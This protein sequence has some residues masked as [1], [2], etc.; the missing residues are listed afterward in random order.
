MKKRWMT[1]KEVMERYDLLP[2]ELYECM[3]P[4]D[5][6]SGYTLKGYHPESVRRYVLAKH[7]DGK[8]YTTEIIDGEEIRVLDSVEIAQD[9]FP[10]WPTDKYDILNDI[11]FKI[12]DVEFIF[13][14]LEGHP[15]P[16]ERIAE[17][18]GQ[19]AEARQENEALRAE[20]EKLKTE[21]AEAEELAAADPENLTDKQALALKVILM[22]H[23]G[24]T[25]KEVG[26]EL[27]PNAQSS[28]AQKRRV[29]R[30]Q[31]QAKALLS[32]GDKPAP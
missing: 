20:V 13:A 2:G 25:I 15:L 31:K 27:F 30:V 17:L 32:G 10:I 5:L 11:K 28:D 3:F 19:L 24:K 29:Y 23:E 26:E 22:R 8:Q 16:S 1:G 12:N 7:C 14:R 21:L 6:R 4:H 9:E 18:E